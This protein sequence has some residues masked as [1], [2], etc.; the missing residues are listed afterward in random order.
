MQTTRIQLN[1]R[2]SRINV[3]KTLP[4]AELNKRYIIRV[5]QLTIPAMSSGLILNQELFTIER[6]CVAGVNHTVD[7]EIQPVAELPTLSGHLS[8]EFI[9]ENVK[10]V[11]QLVY[12]MNAFFRQR[13][14]KLVTS[15]IPFDD[16]GDWYDVPDEFNKQANSDWYTVQSTELG[17]KI[18]GAIEAI[19][20]S[21]GRIGFKFS[22]SGQKLF[23]IRFS[24]EGKRIF[25][26][27]ERYIAIDSLKTFTS[28]LDGTGDVISSIPDPALTEAIV[29][30]TPNSI[31]SAS[32]EIPS[33]KPISNM[34]D[35]KG[36]ATLFL[37]TLA[38]TLLPTIS[39]P[40]F[41]D[42][43]RLKSIRREL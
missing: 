1:A 20:R 19:Y 16:G 25:G 37:T 21:D 39:V 14:V 32:F 23:V 6:R 38:L 5:E 40:C 29:C 22:P 35:L 3:Y 10:T 9:P 17:Q 33:L 24:D 34:A 12:Q 13:L 41:I 28:Y 18:S 2:E 11:S 27:G 30:V 4:S 15:T 7:G 31:I 26:W 42:S 8:K 36:A 43:I